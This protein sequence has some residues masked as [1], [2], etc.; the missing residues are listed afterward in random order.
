M[1]GIANYISSKGLKPAIWTNVAFTNESYANANKSFFVTG[2]NGD[3]V[4][5]RWLGYAIDGS[6]PKALD[7][8]I[9][10][11]ICGICQDGMALF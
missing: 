9:K 2:S 7:N 8:L 6:N 3:P 11:Y 10:T 5:G 4:T 1:D